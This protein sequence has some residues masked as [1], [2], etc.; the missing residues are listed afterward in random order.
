MPLYRKCLCGE[1]CE[2]A[3]WQ[4]RFHAAYIYRN[5]V[6]ANTSQ[7]RGHMYMQIEC[8]VWCAPRP[9][10]Q[11]L[12]SR[13]SLPSERLRQAKSSPS[14]SGILIKFATAALYLCGPAILCKS[15]RLMKICG[16]LRPCVRPRTKSRSSLS[17]ETFISRLCVCTESESIIVRKE[18]RRAFYARGLLQ[19]KQQS[20]W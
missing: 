19:T 10:P 1:K 14:H 20:N 2:R 7:K 12:A 4:A 3:S 13:F 11:H 17:G 9:H 16:L 5:H 6:F 15:T 8:G 18:W